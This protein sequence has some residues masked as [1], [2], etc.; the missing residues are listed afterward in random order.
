VIVPKK[1]SKEEK[2]LIQDL[3]EKQGENGLSKDD[4][5]VFRRVFG[6]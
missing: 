5:G 4:G 1:L 6:G 2:K 3:A